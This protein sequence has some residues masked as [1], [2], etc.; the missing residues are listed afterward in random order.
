MFYTLTKLLKL[1]IRT[2]HSAAFAYYYDPVI[3]RNKLTPL[4]IFRDP[5]MRKRKRVSK[6]FMFYFYVFYRMYTNIQKCYG[7]V[8]YPFMNFMGHGV[9]CVLIPKISKVL[10][11]AISRQNY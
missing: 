6:K 9:A 8:V 3:L 7:L 4:S 5:A 2:R 10:T 1:R 11:F